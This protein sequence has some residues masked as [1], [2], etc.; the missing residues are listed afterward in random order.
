MP[1]SFAA[2]RMKPEKHCPVDRTARAVVDGDLLVD[3]TAELIQF[4]I[5]FSICVSS[6]WVRVSAERANDASPCCGPEPVTLCRD[7]S[8]GELGSD[9]FAAHHRPIAGLRLR[10]AVVAMRRCI[11]MAAH[12]TAARREVWVHRYGPACCGREIAAS[13]H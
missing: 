10:C 2:Q 12:Q 11:S 5:R 8:P 13:A 7:G 9:R 6:T 1:K 4:S 3:M